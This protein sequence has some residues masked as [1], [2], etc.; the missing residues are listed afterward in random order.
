MERRKGENDKGKETGKEGKG[1]AREEERRR[2]NFV[3]L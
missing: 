3:Q 2:G 1:K